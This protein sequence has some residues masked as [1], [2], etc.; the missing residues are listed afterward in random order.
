MER[1]CAITQGISS[2][3][4]DR[5]LINSDAFETVICSNSSCGVLSASTQQCH[6]CSSPVVHILIPYSMKLLIQQ[7]Y[8]MGIKVILHTKK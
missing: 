8:T 7:C 1:D 4:E 2:F 3:L 5:L 6:I